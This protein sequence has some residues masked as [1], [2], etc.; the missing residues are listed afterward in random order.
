[1]VFLEGYLIGLAMIVFIGPVFFTLLQS[2]FRFGKLSGIM[3]AIGIIVSDIVCVLIYYFGLNRI[4]LPAS[5]N[6]IIALTGAIILIGLGIKYLLQKPPNSEVSFASNLNLVSSFTKGFAVNFVNP[7]VFVVWAGIFVFAKESYSTQ[8]EVQYHLIAVLAGI[9]TTDLLKVLLA[10]K[11]KPFLKPKIL[12][13]TT[14]FFGIVMI[15]FAFR[16]ILYLYT[17]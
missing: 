1:M 4:E 3:V 9:L 8:T 11:I 2:A 15:G 7:F 10:D 17:L 16:L 14:K 13:K 5:S 12:E 6:Y